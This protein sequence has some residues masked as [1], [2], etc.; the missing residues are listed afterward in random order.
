MAFGMCV[1]STPGSLPP[2]AFSAIADELK[3]R[4]L[5][6]DLLDHLGTERAATVMLAVTVDRTR[7]RREKRTASAR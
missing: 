3:R 4:G 5:L 1:Q 6:T 2:G 7:G